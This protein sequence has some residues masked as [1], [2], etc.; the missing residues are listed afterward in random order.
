MDLELNNEHRCT[1][2]SILD[3]VF[4]NLKKKFRGYPPKKVEKK[5]GLKWLEMAE[6]G[7]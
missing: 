4:F 6:N 7:F 2:L 5:H 3:H 1:Y